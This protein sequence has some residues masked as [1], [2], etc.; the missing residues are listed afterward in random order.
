MGL[1]IEHSS[2]LVEY[3]LFLSNKDIFDDDF[4]FINKKKGINSS[5]IM[6]NEIILIMKFLFSHF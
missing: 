2:V 6:T 3:S 5:K 1:L 4:Y